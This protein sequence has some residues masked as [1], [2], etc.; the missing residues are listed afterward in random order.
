MLPDRERQALKKKIK[1]YFNND[2]RR[3]A[4]AALR[5]QDDGYGDTDIMNILNA[6]YEAG[7]H[8]VWQEGCDDGTD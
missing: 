3:L 4:D 7:R 6:A 5:L 2:D 1:E 8:Q